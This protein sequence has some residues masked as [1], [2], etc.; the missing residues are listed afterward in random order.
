[1]FDV[2][3]RIEANEARLAAS[4]GDAP[5]ENGGDAP[6]TGQEAAAANTAAAA[7]VE[8]VI[9]AAGIADE[10]KGGDNQPA[11]NQ[12]DADAI[13]ISKLDVLSGGKFKTQEDLLSALT[14][15]EQFDTVK[16]E[17]DTYKQTNRFANE[18][19]QKRNEL[20]L[21]GAS[22][23]TLKS[24][25]KLNDLGDLAQ[26]S[27]VE[28]KVAKLI[29]VDGYSEKLARNTVEKEFPI[30]STYDDDEKEL[31]EEKLAHSANQDR[32]SLEKFKVDVSSPASDAKIQNIVSKEQLTAD[33]KPI[34]ADFNT[35]FS[36]MMT[37][38][39]NGEEGDKAVTYPVVV[40]DEGKAFMNQVVQ[41]FLIT[42]DMPLTQANYD[43]ALKFAKGEWIKA[44]VGTIV[45]AYGKEKDKYWEKYYTEKYENIGGLPRQ[46]R[47]AITVEA[48]AEERAFKKNTFGVD[49]SK[50]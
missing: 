47:K 45:E 38:N 5:I 20:I 48:V 1:M 42:N 27:P 3:Q 30:D 7:A 9:P 19:E 13:F 39:V 21:G 24:F 28:A 22:K 50:A 2:E 11:N 35:K 4:A 40:N 6:A 15:A 36:T 34:L 43:E 10:N 23:E 18:F 33:L 14:K 26:L 12:V 49:L 29:L 31:L 25:E 37:L 41:D 32:K 8:K 16:T 17:Y 46:D 44:N